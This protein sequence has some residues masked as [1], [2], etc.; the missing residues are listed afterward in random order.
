MTRTQLFLAISS[1][2]VV[3]GVTVACVMA[4]AQAQAPL[5]TG[6]TECVLVYKVPFTFADRIERGEMPDK[7][8]RIPAGWSVVSGGGEGQT[9]LMCRTG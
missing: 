5:T 9:L 3:G 2:F 1:A 4:Q 7:T 8:A 6:Q